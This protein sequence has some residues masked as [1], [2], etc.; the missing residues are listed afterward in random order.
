[1]TLN[2]YIAYF[3]GVAVSNKIIGH[4]HN[5]DVKFRRIDIEEVLG[6]LKTNMSGLSMFLENPELRVVDGRSDNYRQEWQGAFLIL[7]KIKPGDINAQIS[8]LNQTLTV[9]EQILAKIKNDAAKES[10]QANYAWP[11]KG[12]DFNSVRINKVGPV[13]TTWYGWRL[14]F[15]L[16]Q[17]F[18]N[19]LILQNNEWYNDTKF[20]I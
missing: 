17:T 2:Q 7:N 15:T 8:V 1:M 9:C 10:M 16:N 11:I 14:T 3:E 19:G 18:N 12:F 20:T 4:T 6:D 5:G 13:F